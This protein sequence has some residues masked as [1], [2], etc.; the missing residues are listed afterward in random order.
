MKP[1]MNQCLIY[2]KPLERLLKQ[3][4]PK[5][6]GGTDVNVLSWSPLVG[7]LI[8]TGALR[9]PCTAACGSQLS[10]GG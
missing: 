2:Y 7:E 6:H 5:A 10:Q 8:V 4:R 1:A 3:L 9:V